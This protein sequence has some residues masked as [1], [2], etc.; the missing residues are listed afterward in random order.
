MQQLVV[1]F[2]HTLSCL[3]YAAFDLGAADSRL[4]VG[5]RT[6]TFVKWLVLAEVL[7]L[8][9]A[10]L[11]TDDD[12]T[13]LDNP[14]ASFEPTQY[15]FRHQAEEGRGCEARPNGGL[16]YVRNT[17]P[18]L[19]MLARMLSKRSDIESNANRLDQD[20]VL[21]AATAAGVT[22]CAFPTER[23]AG[24]CPRAQRPW[25]PVGAL[26]T[27]HAHCCGRRDDKAALAERMAIAVATRPE[28]RFAD[29]DR[30]P[31]P[32]TGKFEDSCSYGGAARGSF[33][34]LC[35]H[36]VLWL[37]SMLL[38]FGACLW[39]RRQKS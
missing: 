33:V 9:E 19:D 13:L 14:F 38:C 2:S 25:T 4:Q 17:A 30:Q 18:V 3:R 27:Y 6:I 32:S 5:Y 23:F 8:V 1:L 28:L 36:S 24:H 10:V 11:F 35:V 16:L 12:V 29:V 15:E 31:L 21:G 37:C 39:H 22:R 20:Y 26:V 34:R 7:P